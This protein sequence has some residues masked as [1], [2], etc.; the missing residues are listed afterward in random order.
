MTGF[1]SDQEKGLRRTI[2]LDGLPDDVRSGLLAFDIDGDGEISREEL[3]RAAEV[4][5][6]SV[7]SVSRMTKIIVA[8]TAL[9]ALVVGCNGGLTY[10]IIEATKEYTVKGTMLS[11]P[12]GD[13]ISVNTN[14]ISIPVATLAFAPGY[15]AANLAA[16]SF[17][18]ANDDT[19]YHRR[20][21]S[22]DVVQDTSVI[23]K[24]TAGDV[25]SYTG[26]ST[27]QITLADS[28]NWNK[29]AS[30]TRCSSLNVHLTPELDAA[31]DKAVQAF[32]TPNGRKLLGFSCW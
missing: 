26:G 5:R 10:A 31:I 6:D 22:V 19:L 16:I 32:G 25:L 1:S 27:L 2:A 21:Q 3:I 30:C 28:T 29:Q 15:V 23:V 11:T 17:G 18:S 9:L 12:Y 20:V 8:L 4:Y 7:R 13:A 14:E 24:T